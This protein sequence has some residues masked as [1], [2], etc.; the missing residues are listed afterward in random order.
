ME[1]LIGTIW[2]DLDVRSGHRLVVVVD[3][4]FNTGEI[5]IKNVLTH[6]ETILKRNG[7]KPNATGKRGFERI[8]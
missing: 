8:D 7:L 6:K 5:T 4:D 2:Q 3:Q 1:R